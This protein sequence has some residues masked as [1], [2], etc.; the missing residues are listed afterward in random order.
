MLKK[1]V[2]ALAVASI[3]L[4]VGNASAVDT[5]SVNSAEGYFDA[6]EQIHGSTNSEFIISLASDIIIGSGTTIKNNHTFDNGNTVTILGNGHKIK[7]EVGGN[8]KMHVNSGATLNLGQDGDADG[9]LEIEGAGNGIAAEA[10]LI[11]MDASTVNMYDGV[12]L[13]NNYSMSYMLGGT[14]I[15]INNNCTFNMYGGSIHHNI[16]TVTE[17][18]GAILLDGHGSTLNVLGGE[19]TDNESPEWGGAIIAFNPNTVNIKN[20]TISR[21][22]A[23]YYGGAIAAY[24]STVNIEN[25]VFE[26]NDAMIG[27]AIVNQE[28]TINVKSSTFKNNTGT[29]GG[30]IVNIDGPLTVE[31]STFEGNTVTGFA[32]AIYND[33]NQ[34]AIGTVTSK[35]NVY[36]N[37]SAA[38]GGAI[39]SANVLTSVN[40]VVTGNTAEVGGGVYLEQDSAD[41]STTKIY[42]NKATTNANDLFIG[43]GVTAI[44]LMDASTMGGTVR[45]G[46][47]TVST[48]NW[49]KDDE[50]NRYALDNATD[51]VAYNSVAA[52]TEYSLT[53][54]GDKAVNPTPDP[55]P[56]PTPESV[57][58]EE[59]PENPAT[60]DNIDAYARLLCAGIIGLFFTIFIIRKT[61]PKEN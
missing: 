8:N 21:N 49:F 5:I 23:T 43:A 48:G 20:A 32:G 19:I 36:K 35:N 1:I 40:D 12:S 3:L 42:N 54:S 44:Q 16:N 18:G 41:L 30:A 27:G 2:P 52:G 58:P 11:V 14:A 29:Y 53:V 28:A 34:T 38:T 46:E 7:Y 39:F 17:F 55:T 60:D 47:E 10:S 57:T 51:I 6:I 24:L 15:N 56:D 37:N 22:K 31:D 45:Y 59:I 50:N 9:T 26:G 4:P 13:S 25:T 61:T 33:V